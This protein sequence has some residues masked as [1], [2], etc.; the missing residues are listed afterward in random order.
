MY[1]PANTYENRLNAYSLFDINL[2][3][4]IERATDERSCIGGDDTISIRKCI[5]VGKMAVQALVVLVHFMHSEGNALGT[6]G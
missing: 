5:R 2:V 6:I 3:V 1:A 4:A